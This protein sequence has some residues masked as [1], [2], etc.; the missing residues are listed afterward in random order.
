MSVS[1]GRSRGPVRQSL[2]EETDELREEP[3]RISCARTAAASALGWRVSRRHGF[4]RRAARAT[5]RRSRRPVLCAGQHRALSCRSIPNRRCARRIASS[6]GAFNGWR[7][8]ARA[9]PQACTD[10]HGRAGVAMAGSEAA[11]KTAVTADCVAIRKCTD[12]G[13][14]RACVAL[15]QEVWGFSRRGTRSAADVRRWLPRSA[16]R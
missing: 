11:G 4:L 3:G 5:G 9:G 12:A 16:A 1:T 7:T 2:Q 13:E 6:R 10:S 14:L 8:A 15:Q